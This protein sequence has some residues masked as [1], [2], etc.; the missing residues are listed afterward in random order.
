[1]ARKV[2]NT[3]YVRPEMTRDGTGR[4]R[5]TKPDFLLA[6]IKDTETNHT[7]LYIEE[8]PKVKFYVANK[9]QE[10]PAIYIPKADVSERLC[11]Y[12]DR[13]IELA[14]ALGKKSEFFDAIRGG[15]KYLFMR[16]VY[17]NPNLYMADIDVEDYFKSSFTWENGD[18][19]KVPLKKGFS[20]IEVDISHYK[21]FPFSRTAPC[22][23][24]TINHFDFSTKTF[25]ST[26]LRNPANPQIAEMENNIQG[27][28]N[29]H[30]MPELLEEDKDCKFVFYFVNTEQEVIST[31]FSV[32]HRT[33]PDFVG[34]WAIDY[35]MLTILNR[36]KKLNMDIPGTICHPEVPDK[37]KYVHFHE[38]TTEISY[39]GD[40]GG[41]E[42]KAGHKSRRWHWFQASGKTQFY[43]QMSLYSNMRKIITL[44]SYRLDA[45]GL[46]EVKVQKVDY[47]DHGYTLKTAM[48]DNFQLFMRY[49]LKD[50][51]VQYKIEQKVDDLSKYILFTG[52]T[53]LQKGVK[54][55]YVIKNSIMDSFWK[56]GLVVG[57]TV[58]YD[59]KD[60]IPGAIV[61]DPQLLLKRG[62]KINGKESFLF[63]NV[64]DLDAASMYPNIM[65][66]A[67]VAKSTLLGRI[68][69][70]VRR[71]EK[72]GKEIHMNISGP[73]INSSLQTIDA[74]ILD[75]G[76]KFFNLPN[77]ESILK[78]YK[79]YTK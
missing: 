68:Y 50:T 78:D 55:S 6:T 57:N 22:A 23:I 11:R 36:M 71:D 15:N 41:G 63:E 10:F 61:S 75:I 21:G 8:K 17:R 74:S 77:L 18:V 28:I 79:E 7:E 37:F 58:S 31:Y 35:D 56:D 5:E 24:N 76:A 1:M 4:L 33:E 9:R 52:N 67:N 19:L 65:I 45:I 66:F 25:Y 20:D 44:P 34:F 3:M 42:K 54:I 13:E 26:I 32:I 39:G 59:I 2:L 12:T 62:I 14:T 64:I 69:E 47:K 53:R 40:G 51:Y 27:F 38:D 60:F 29:N 16:D 48:R 70:L 46:S 43:D 73:E 30:M 72:T 49:A